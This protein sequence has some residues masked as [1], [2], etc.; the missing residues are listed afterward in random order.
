MS[1]ELAFLWLSCKSEIRLR[2]HGREGQRMRVPAEIL[3]PAAVRSALSRASIFQ[4]WDTPRMSDTASAAEWAAGLA[5]YESRIIG[6]VLV[7]TTGSPGLQQL[8][9]PLQRDVR[10]YWMY[11]DVFSIVSVDIVE[12]IL[13]PTP[14]FAMTRNA[15][16]IYQSMFFEI[17][18]ASEERLLKL[19][20]RGG[21]TVSEYLKSWSMVYKLDSCAS[22]STIAISV[23]TGF[24]WLIGTRHLRSWGFPVFIADGSRR[25]RPGMTLVKHLW[26]GIELQSSKPE[27]V[28]G[29]GTFAPAQLVKIADVIRGMMGGNGMGEELRKEAA[30]QIALLQGTSDA[31][32]R[33]SLNISERVYKTELLVRALVLA[34]YLS[35][36]DDLNEVILMAIR[37]CRLILQTSFRSSRVF[38]RVLLVSV[39][40]YPCTSRIPYSCKGGYPR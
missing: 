34:S 18:T 21:K 11:L 3:Y 14:V 20:G 17:T 38:R 24:A 28:E 27:A 30:S 40:V 13:F 10:D 16:S 5:A 32:M 9:E 29:D 23:P 2:L 22:R 6:F 12:C 4:S 8:L 7:R 1:G 39:I 25:T 37:Q 15:R 26:K 31:M 35:A 36:P 33:H 19:T